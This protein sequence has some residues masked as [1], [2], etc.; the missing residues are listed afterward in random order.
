METGEEVVGLSRMNNILGGRRQGLGAPP[1]RFKSRDKGEANLEL[2]CPPCN[3]A[4][5]WLFHPRRLYFCLSCKSICNCRFQFTTI[6]VRRI[7]PL[8]VRIE[9]RKLTRS[10]PT[11]ARHTCWIRHAFGRNCD[12]PLLYCMDT[13]NGTPIKLPFHCT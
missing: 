4:S 5:S 12:L 7:P 2:R 3:K 10:S 6:M 8:S 1:A 9:A 13:V 11:T